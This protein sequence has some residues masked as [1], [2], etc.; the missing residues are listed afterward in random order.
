MPHDDS[1][2]EPIEIS[3]IVPMPCRL[4]GQPAEIET[5]EALC[6]YHRGACEIII[7]A[8][9]DDVQAAA[10]ADNLSKNIRYA[11]VDDANDFNRAC[12]VGAKA[13]RNDVLLF[14]HP[15]LQISPHALS[16][17]LCYFRQADTFGVSP[18][19]RS[20]DGHIADACL[21]IPYLQKNQIRLHN[22][23]LDAETDFFPRPLITLRNVTGVMLLNR[24]K[25]M[26]IQPVDQQPGML[27]NLCVA[28]WL[29]NWRCYCA[30]EARVSVPLNLKDLPEFSLTPGEKIHPADCPATETSKNITDVIAY[31]GSYYDRS[32]NTRFRA[33]IGL[34]KR[35]TGDKGMDYSGEAEIIAATRLHNAF[36]DSA[37]LDIGCGRRKFPGAI[38]MDMY[39]GQAVDLVHNLDSI[40]WPIRDESFDL[41]IASHILEH[42]QD[43]GGVLLETHRILRP[44]GTL[45]VRCPHFSSRDSYRNPTHVRHLSYEAIAEMLVQEGDTMQHDLSCGRAPFRLIQTQLKFIGGSR[46]KLGRFLAERKARVWEQYWSRILPAREICWQLRK[47]TI[48]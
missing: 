23:D 36:P 32:H 39:P 17:M 19:I 1:F 48:G 33:V 34:P 43:F 46:A 12:W 26:D 25:L 8:R 15:A 42:V 13:A 22:W 21:Q 4:D 37:I 38:G 7:V 30:A 29:R 27:N 47:R 31:F 24:T 20:A 5:A 28:A 14:L 6:Q 40:P 18:L 10:A 45:I 9:S 35:K 16:A 3:I 2:A 44:E 41:V 11:Y